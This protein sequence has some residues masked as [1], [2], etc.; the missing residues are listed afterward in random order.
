MQEIH[1]NIEI[2]LHWSSWLTRCQGRTVSAG[3]MNKQAVQI[4]VV[5]GGFMIFLTFQ[6]SKHHQEAVGKSFPKMTS[7]LLSFSIV[8]PRWSLKQVFFTQGSGKPFFKCNFL[9][10]VTTG[11]SLVQPQVI[12]ICLG[13]IVLRAPG[14]KSQRELYMKLC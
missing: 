4:N 12:T 5:I 14:L 9:K 1:I 7:T 10:V 8:K 13:Q 11:E 2:R 6:S 3:G